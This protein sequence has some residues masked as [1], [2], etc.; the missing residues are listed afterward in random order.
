[1]ASL[2]YRHAGEGTVANDS[3]HYLFTPSSCTQEEGWGGGSCRI[4]TKYRQSRI[5][6]IYFAMSYMLASSERL[7]ESA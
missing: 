6:E 4:P 5:Y 1:M 2:L 7:R 3:G